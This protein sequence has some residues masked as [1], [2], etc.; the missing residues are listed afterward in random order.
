MKAYGNIYE[1]YGMADEQV[2]DEADDEDWELVGNE[3]DDLTFAMQSIAYKS[4]A[5]G[6]AASKAGGVTFTKGTKDTVLLS[7]LKRT[8]GQTSFSGGKICQWLQD[9]WFGG[10]VPSKRLSICLATVGDCTV[11]VAT[12]QKHLVVEKQ[13]KY[14]SLMPWRTLLMPFLGLW[15]RTAHPTCRMLSSPCLWR[16]ILAFLLAGR[17]KN[18]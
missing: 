6:G 1:K 11:C 18:D 15:R 5:A 10:C 13:R 7:A 3:E 2:Y 17:Q 12:G 16:T 9:K 14:S 8:K 4:Q